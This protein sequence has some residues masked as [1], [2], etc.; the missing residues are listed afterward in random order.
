M[1]Y[2]LFTDIGADL[3]YEY[4]QAHDIGFLPFALTIDGQDI[5]GSIEPDDP[6]YMELSAFF[7]KLRAGAPVKTAQLTTELVKERFTPVL[8]SGRDILYIALSSGV[9]GAL[10][11]ARLAS[12]ELLQQFPERKIMLLDS[13]C[14]SRGV[15]LLVMIAVKKQQEG[16]PLDALLA[17]LEDIRLSI[18]HWVTVDDL[19]HLKRGGR[20]SGTSAALG[21]VLAIKPI[22][23]MNKEGKLSVIDKVQGRKRS[24]KY[25]V[26]M[27]ARDIRQP[28]SEPLLI[29]HAD[30]PEDAEYVASLVRE[31]FHVEPDISCMWHNVGAHVGPGA[32]AVIF[33]SDKERPD[34]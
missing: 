17:H 13:L 31:K 28:I 19:G 6:Q 20:M 32:V 29:A 1:S 12:E 11:C 25:L 8:E 30:V 16:M 33:I 24:L 2:K 5:M 10:N 4:T 7:A 15:G 26:E 21:T 3:L 22:I 27:A 9:T 14:A 34:A 23:T 18:H